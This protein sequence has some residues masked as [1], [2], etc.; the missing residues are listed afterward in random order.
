MASRGPVARQAAQRWLLGRVTATI[1]LFALMLSGCGKSNHDGPSGDGGGD[2]GDTETGGGATGTAGTGQGA[3]GHGGIGQ[4]GTGGASARNL[5]VTEVRASSLTK[6]DLL[7]TI[8]NSPSMA[9]KQQLLAQAIPA[10]LERLRAPSDSTPGLKPIDD[11]HLAVISSSLGAHGATMPDALCTA[12]S[13]NDHAQ[14]LGKLRGITGTYGNQGFLAWDP[15]GKAKPPGSS[16]ASAFADKAAELITSAGA[17][18][19]SQPA[20]LEAWYRFLV[21]P[22]PPANIYIAPGGQAQ[23][24]GVDEIV[25]SQRRAFLRPDSV[26]IIGVL[27]DGNDC[28]LTDEGYGWLAARRDPNFRSTSQCQTDPNDP[29]C[30]SCGEPTA[31]AGCPSIQADTEC[32]KGTHL[33]AAEDDIDL[34]CWDQKRRYGFE[35]VYPVSRYAGALQSPTV[36]QRSTGQTAPNPLFSR[37]E[38][39]APRDKSMVRLFAIAGV[40]W[41]DIAATESLTSP[42][43]LRYMT[44]RELLDDERWKV[45]L[46]DPHAS[47]PILPTDPLMLETTRERGGS[48]PITGDSLAPSAASDLTAN[49]INGGEHAESLN[50]LQAACIFPTGA[51]AAETFAKAR[52]SGRVL[53]L[54]KE[55]GDIAT[56]ASVCPK[57]LSAASPSYGYL[58]A[59]DALVNDIQPLL[60]ERCLP[61]SLPIDETSGALRCSV[62]AVLEPGSCDCAAAGFVEV[63][64]AGVV[65]LAR[66]Q[67]RTGQGCDTATSPSCASLCTCEIPRLEGGAAEQCLGDPVPPSETGY[68]YISAEANEPNV[69]NAALVAGCPAMSH[70]LLR[71]TGTT[72]SSNATTLLM[73]EGASLGNP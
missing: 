49:P 4:S 28:S 48:N 27:T 22:E 16:D 12:P 34:R 39:A 30:Q 62:I 65:D 56:L 19:C 9:D 45:I 32:I 37:G 67:L 42:D 29:C 11:L 70:R 35:L 13:E 31:H 52:P 26:L 57:V 10:L 1:V 63:T 72:A 59:V 71:F 55:V 2:G 41:Q 46:G 61:R 25:L 47:P 69:G 5:F 18:G 20:S 53:E 66:R 24:S 51:T 43:T 50:E 73:C 8:D 64:D 54:V 36:T 6:V 38:G 60:Q 21:D 15:L 40:P 17:I 7:L 44:T 23:V 33:S 3:A 14:L 58:P 68:C